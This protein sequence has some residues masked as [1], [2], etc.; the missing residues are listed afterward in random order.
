MKNS[1]FEVGNVFDTR[2]SGKAEIVEYISSK[3]V[4]VKFLNSGNIKSVNTS[5]LRT[6]RI[7]DA[8]LFAKTFWL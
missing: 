5:N 8:E 2:E 7:K 4:V 3:Q 6:G 1:I